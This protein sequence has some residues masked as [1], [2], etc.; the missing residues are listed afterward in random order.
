MVNSVVRYLRGN[1][2]FPALGEAYELRKPGTTRG[3]TD[4]KD[5]DANGESAAGD[6]ATDAQA[7]AS[8]DSTQPRE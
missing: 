7:A 4:P 5:E 3:L 2:M 1:D 6:A 8:A